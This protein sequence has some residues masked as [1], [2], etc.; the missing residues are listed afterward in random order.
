MAY[1]PAGAPPRPALR[2]Y[3][4]GTIVPISHVRPVSP[5]TWKLWLNGIYEH[6]NGAPQREYARLRNMRYTIP[7]F[8]RMYK[9]LG[10]K[11][12]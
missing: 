12:W 5:L 6:I 3:W 7:Q 4:E 1:S 10:W 2:V 11:L 8:K 9:L